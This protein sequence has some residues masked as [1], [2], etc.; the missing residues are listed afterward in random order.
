MLLME[1][2]NFRGLL[3][4]DAEEAEELAVLSRGITPVHWLKV[5]HHGSRYS[6]GEAFLKQ[7]KPL[8]A[9]ISYGEGNR[10]GHPHKETLDRLEAYGSFMLSTPDWGAI[11]IECGARLRVTGFCKSHGS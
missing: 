3:T 11:T 9:T 1:T 4:G 10:Y 5:E 8:Y 7:I 6:T 2:V